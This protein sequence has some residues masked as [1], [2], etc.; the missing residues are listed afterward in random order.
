MDCG[1]SMSVSHG[2]QSPIDPTTAAMKERE[3]RPALVVRKGTNEG[4]DQRITMGRTGD[5]QEIHGRGRG[6]VK[7]VVEGH[8]VSV[9]LLGSR[10]VDE[11]Q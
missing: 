6:A 8:R 1:V 3:Y 5:G 2:G 4:Q 10:R 9:W 7:C 11:G